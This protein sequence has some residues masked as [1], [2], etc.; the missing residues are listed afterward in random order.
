[1]KAIVATVIVVLCCTEA[2]AD[3]LNDLPDIACAQASSALER[4]Q[5]GCPIA[6][7]AAAEPRAAASPRDR[8]K[9]D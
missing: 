3:D 6:N 7:T 2:W 1:M 4:E 5:I 8:G 9:D